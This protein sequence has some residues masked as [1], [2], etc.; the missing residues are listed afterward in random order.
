MTHN[1]GVRRTTVDVSIATHPTR[2]GGRLTVGATLLSAVLLAGCSSDV[3]SGRNTTAATSMRPS[4]SP[5]ATGSLSRSEQPLSPEQELAKDAE[6]FKGILKGN[7]NT[8]NDPAF[9]ANLTK[10][11]SLPDLSTHFAADH[12]KSY[13]IYEGATYGL[14]FDPKEEG[15][16][17]DTADIY[18][19]DETYPGL[20]SGTTVVQSW[21]GADGKIIK[22]NER[23]PKRNI[24]PRSRL[25]D[26]TSQVLVG[27]VTDVTVG[28][29]IDGV[30]Y[31]LEG[32]IPKDLKIIYMRTDGCTEISTFRNIRDFDQATGRQ[33]LSS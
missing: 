5:S 13:D 11:L 14:W 9:W 19:K 23:K 3:P 7:L 18:I 32:K 21:V 16:S 8:K 2:R 6:A 26:V 22:N 28:Q 31:T 4:E 25:Y 17:F 1:E 30:G 24:I 10:L 15:A 12:E 27:R 20:K 33:K 29:Q